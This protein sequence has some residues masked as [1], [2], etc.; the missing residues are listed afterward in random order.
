MTS[1]TD[2]TPASVFNLFST[3]HTYVYETEERVVKRE[4]LT[5]REQKLNS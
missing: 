1:Q 4:G 2:E 5:M 3:I